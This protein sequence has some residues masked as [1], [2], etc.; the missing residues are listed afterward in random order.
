MVILQ[1]ILLVILA[2]FMH[3]IR[4]LKSQSN[5][6]KKSK[7]RNNPEEIYENPDEIKDDAYGN[8]EQMEDEQSTYTAL[9]RTGRTIAR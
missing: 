3:L 8:N 6:E 4:R 2:Y 5:L 7:N 1:V 9:K